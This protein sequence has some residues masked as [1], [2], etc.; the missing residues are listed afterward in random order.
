MYL[1][2]EL[3]KTKGARTGLSGMDVVKW[4]WKAG[5]FERMGVERKREIPGLEKVPPALTLS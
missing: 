2:K 5:F 4:A 3:M 1:V